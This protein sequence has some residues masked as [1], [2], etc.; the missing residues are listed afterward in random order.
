MSLSMHQCLPM[1][2]DVKHEVMIA[3][4]SSKMQVKKP[5]LKVQCVA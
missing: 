1:M 4:M 5:Q 2:D 3:V